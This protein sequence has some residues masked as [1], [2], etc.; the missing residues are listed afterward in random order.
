MVSKAEE[1]MKATCNET[2]GPFKNFTFQTKEVIDEIF[3]SS[4]DS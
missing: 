2:C 3:S 4:N 1:P